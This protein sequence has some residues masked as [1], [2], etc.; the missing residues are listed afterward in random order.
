LLVSNKGKHI[1]L[2]PEALV[3]KPQNYEENDKAEG[4]SQDEG[5]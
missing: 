3:K 4:E 5:H 2:L 1:P